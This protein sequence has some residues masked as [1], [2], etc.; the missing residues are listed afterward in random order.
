MIGRVARPWVRLR[1]AVTLAISRR[2][3]RVGG[4]GAATG[5]ERDDAQRAVAAATAS[6]RPAANGGADDALLGD[7]PADQLGRRDVERRVANLGAG[8]RDRG[9]P[10]SSGPR[11][12]VAPR[13]RSRRRRR[14]RGRSRSSG[15]RRRT[16]SRGARRGRASGYV[17]TLFA[18]S[19]FAATRSAPTITTSTSPPRI[20]EPAAT[21]GISVCG[22][23]ACSSSQA[24]RRAPWRYGR[25]SS[26]Q[27]LI[28]RPAWWAAWTIPSAV[29]N[30]PQASGPVLQ[31]VRIR[32][33]PN[34]RVGSAASPNSASR[35]WSV[36]ASATIASASSR[37]A[38]AID[39]P[40]LDQVADGLVAG[41]HPV[42]GPA[43]VDRRRPGCAQRRRRAAEDRPAGV[44][45][46]VAGPLRGERQPD[47]GDLADRRRAPDDHLAD[48]VGRLG[49]V[50]D[51]DL[52]ELVRQPPLVDERG[53]R[54]GPRGTASGSRSAGRPATGAPA[55]AAA[56][57]SSRR[58]DADTGS[59][60]APAASADARWRACAAP[61]DRRRGLDQLAGELPEE[62]PTG[63]VD[64]STGSAGTAVAG[65]PAPQTGAG[66]GLSGRSGPA[67]AS[68][69]PAGSAGPGSGS[70]VGSANGVSLRSV[71]NVADERSGRV[72]TG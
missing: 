16:G 47:R 13:S 15:R 2:P 57:A 70:R 19:P 60:I 25:V 26:T 53:G 59:R 48:R 22:T 20:S 41:D 43:E 50:V 4:A 69:V 35:P 56:G 5:T 65:W 28:S 45:H 63:E 55:G 42:H 52:D 12:R 49:P 32:S 67:A 51:L 30:W 10:G 17:P 33:G 37:S 62:P 40:V 34:S 11:R 1:V 21:S 58:S 6:A 71:G 24:V 68:I 3:G 14:W 36:V 7:D 39:R 23:P 54:R 18:V 31:W 8:R 46:R 66:G 9:R 38:A 29:P 44:R 72:S 61:G 27:T 64:S